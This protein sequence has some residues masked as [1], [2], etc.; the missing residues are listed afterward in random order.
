MAG[1]KELAS[2]KLVFMLIYL[3]EKGSEVN[4]TEGRRK[5]CIGRESGPS[6][7]SVRIVFGG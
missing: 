5:W 3:H 2:V 1:F 4:P 7:C 6:D